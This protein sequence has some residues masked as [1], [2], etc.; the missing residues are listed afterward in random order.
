LRLDD[1]LEDSEGS[2]TDVGSSMLSW[3][4]ARKYTHQGRE[5]DPGTVPGR[6]AELLT[7]QTN[8]VISRWADE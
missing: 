3:N 8:N 1:T 6:A 4:N 7:F 5:T 2:E